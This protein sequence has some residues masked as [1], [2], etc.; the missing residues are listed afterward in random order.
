[1]EQISVKLS[2]AGTHRRFEIM[3]D[4]NQSLFSNLTTHVSQLAAEGGPAFDVA[5]QDDDGDDIIIARPDELGEAIKSRKDDLL[6]LHTIKKVGEQENVKE[7]IKEEQTEKEAENPPKAENSGNS[8]GIDAVHGYVI[9]DVC[10][11]VIIG[12][13]Y[14]CILCSDYD[15][16]QNCEKTGVHVQHGMIRIVDPLRTYIPWGA[17]LNRP[18]GYHHQQ[19]LPPAFDGFIHRLRVKEKKDQLSE[20]VAKGMRYLTEIK[21]VVT[22]TLATFGNDAN[23][24]VQEDDKKKAEQQKKENTE[25]KKEN[26]EA[27]AEAHVEQKTEIDEEKAKAE[28]PAASGVMKEKK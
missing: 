27:N 12:I 9:C 25:E 5:W 1:M 28:K 16:C 10:D 3:G 22:S 14:K 17:R 2:H 24:E 20:Q 11:A 21:Q 18:P 19:H 8:D 7:N 23:Y 15:L 6:R 13:R 4:D 26:K